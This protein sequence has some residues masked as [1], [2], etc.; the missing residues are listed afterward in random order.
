[1]YCHRNCLLEFFRFLESFL[2]AVCSVERKRDQISNARL[3]ETCQNHVQDLWITTT[4]TKEPYL[5]MQIHFNLR[6]RV[7]K[8]L[9]SEER[10]VGSN[11][12]LSIRLFLKI[13][14]DQ[15]PEAFVSTQGKKLWSIYLI[16]RNET[17]YCVPTLNKKSH[18]FLLIH[19][20]SSLYHQGKSEWIMFMWYREDWQWWDS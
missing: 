4:T 17:I 15:F 11:T 6:L 8:A 3:W 10:L 7:I 1:M 2:F 16:L 12:G 18:T 14:W 13:K 20:N 9:I 5:Y 19:C